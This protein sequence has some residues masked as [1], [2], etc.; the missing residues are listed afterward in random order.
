M[1]AQQLLVIRRVAES[2][3]MLCRAAYEEAA[4]SAYLRGS[5]RCTKPSLFQLVLHRYA[6]QTHLHYALASK[7][8]LM[9]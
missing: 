5:G 3:P 8:A 2:L 1:T 4:L 7:L 9:L 6:A